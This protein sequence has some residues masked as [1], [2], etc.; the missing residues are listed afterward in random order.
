MSKQ[1]QKLSDHHPVEV[2][3]THDRNGNSIYTAT[4]GGFGMRAVHKYEPDMS[5]NDNVLAAVF[6]LV[7]NA[8]YRGVQLSQTSWVFVHL[9]K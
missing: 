4:G 1:H 2:K 9:H 6:K 3:L 8:P 7:K 5:R